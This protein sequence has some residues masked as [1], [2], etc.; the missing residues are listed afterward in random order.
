[1]FKITKRFSHL[2]KVLQVGKK[3]LTHERE[4]ERKST[5]DGRDSFENFL[6]EK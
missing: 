4:R 2:V 5:M 1:M 6:G 3:F